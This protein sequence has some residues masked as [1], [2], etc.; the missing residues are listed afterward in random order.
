MK[1]DV[2]AAESQGLMRFASAHLVFFIASAVSAKFQEIGY[3]MF[4]PTQVLLGAAG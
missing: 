3:A 2:A 1:E 4:A